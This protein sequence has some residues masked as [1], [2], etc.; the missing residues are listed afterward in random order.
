[1][2]TK[3]GW[4]LDLKKRCEAVGWTVAYGSSGHYKATRPDGQSMA[5][6][7]TPTSS[8][9]REN[10]WAQARQFGLDAA[11]AQLQKRLAAEREAKRLADRAADDRL[12][13]SPPA[14]ET[15]EETSPMTVE[16]QIT[17]TPGA[18]GYADGQAIMEIGPV[19]VGH[20]R[21][22]KVVRELADAEELLLADA[23]IRYRCCKPAVLDP[24]QECGKLYH[25]AMSLSGHQNWHSRV[26]P[27]QSAEK[28]AVREPLPPLEEPRSA[29]EGMPPGAIAMLVGTADRFE[30]LAGALDDAADLAN[31]L[32][33]EL[34]EGLAQLPELLV[35]PELQEKAA[36]FD[37]MM[38]ALGQESGPQ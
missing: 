6:A 3:K 20:A 31:S 22:P 19:R 11:E 26:K 27:S 1:M 21:N 9:S 38:G 32:V 16:N 35:S 10:A 2:G 33:T 30:K 23:S 18:L 8:R 13:N 34:R 36:K 12:F 37:R 25:S 28:A 17:Q 24:D 5:W 14:T 4:P 29:P 15:S 7:S